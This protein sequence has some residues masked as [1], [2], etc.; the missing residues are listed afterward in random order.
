MDT[1]YSMQ[2]GLDF[3]LNEDQQMITDMIR[4]Y[5]EERIRPVV[6]KY[7]ESQEFPIEIMKEL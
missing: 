7:D 3:Q 2:E 4:R 6:M 1:T 5:G